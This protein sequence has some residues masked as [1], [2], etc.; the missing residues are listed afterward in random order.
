MSIEHKTQGHALARRTEGGP[1][2]AGVGRHVFVSQLCETCG[3]FPVVSGPRT[4]SAL[5]PRLYRSRPVSTARAGLA[6]AAA[7]VCSRDW[8]PGVAPHKLTYSK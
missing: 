3:L 1:P 5:I 8:R 6:A 7:A 4:E 2:C